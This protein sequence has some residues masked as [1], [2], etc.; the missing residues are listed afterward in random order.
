MYTKIN[1]IELVE[2]RDNAKCIYLIKYYWKEVNWYIELAL[3][4]RTNIY[5]IYNNV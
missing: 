2:M 3:N 5:N 4:K 1:S